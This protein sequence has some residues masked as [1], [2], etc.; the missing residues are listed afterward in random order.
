MGFSAIVRDLPRLV[1]ADR[2]D[3][4]G[5]RG[6]QAGLP[7]HHRQPRIQPARGAQGEG[8][9]SRDPDRPLCL[10]ERLGLAPQ[11]RAGDAAACRPRALPAAVRAGRARA[12]RRPARHLRRPPADPRARH[13]SP[14]PRR[15]GSGR[16]PSGD[17]VKTLLLLPGS[18]KGEVEPADRAVPRDACDILRGRG[19]RLRVLLPTVPNVRA[20]VEAATAGWPEPPEIIADAAGKW[21]AFGAS[22]CRTLRVGNRVAGTGARRRA[23][24]FLLQARLAGQQADASWSP[25]GRLRCPI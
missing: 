7:G 5:D 12:P 13:R 21:R 11:S 9:G 16:V 6:R 3:G 22:R 1:Q 19:N 10:P 8:G 25:H 14:R 23:A 17:A 20:M 2:R 18:R 4:A 15:S 24:G